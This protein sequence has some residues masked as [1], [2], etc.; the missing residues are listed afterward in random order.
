MADGS[1]L[2]ILE[3]T[4]KEVSRRRFAKGVIGGGA[5]VSSAGYLLETSAAHSA[6]GPLC[7]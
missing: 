6:D 1:N 4:P 5:A 7:A 3:N 2:K